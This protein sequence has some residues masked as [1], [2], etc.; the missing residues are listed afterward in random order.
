MHS[1]DIQIVICG[2]AGDGTIATGDIL[3]RAM[4]R[5][6]YKVISFDIYPA[7]IRGFGKCVA[8]V[9]I[10]TEQVYSLKPQCEILVSLDDSHAI[11]HVAEVRDFGAVVYEG[12]PISHVPEGGH[13]SAHVKPGQLPYALSQRQVSEQATGSGRSRNIVSLGF[14]AGLWN[15][16]AK[17]FREIITEKF[18]RKGTAVAESNM[19][20]F[21]AGFEVGAATFKL[22]DVALGPPTHAAE[23]ADVQMMTG[24]GAVVRACLEAGIDAFFGYPI[25]PATPIMERLFVEMPKAGAVALQ[26]ED[27]ISAI[28]ATL[29]ASYAGARAATATSGPGLALMTEMLGLGVMAEVPAVVFAC[30]RG[31]P[32][33]GLPTKTEQSDLNLAVHGGA[34]DAQRIVLAPTNVEGC[35]RCA[36]KAFDL[37]EQFQTPVI[38]LLDLYL[39]NRY[40]TV[41]PPKENPFEPK[42]AAGP[43]ALDEHEP[44]RRYATT[45]EF[46]SPRTLPGHE[47]GMHTITGLE[48]DEFGHPNDQSAVHMAM[49]AKRHR[50]LAGALARRDFNLCKRFG[51]EG[52]VD[53]GI[54]SWGS[55]F[56]ECLEAMLAAQAEGIRCAAM[57]VVML[58]PLPVDPIADFF[59]DCQEVLVP[60]L[61]YEGQ[62]ANLVTAAVGQPVS[63]LNRV[64][65]APMQFDEILDHVKSLA[66]GRTAA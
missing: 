58:S 16:P 64:T 1:T 56:G 65:G 24:N 40:E 26:T 63:R 66:R 52:P 49:S 39:C 8:R 22:D 44:Y 59:A 19:R 27:E 21:E 30:Q 53:V 45:R 60:E 32:A 36:G 20:A 54:L 7:E 4:A 3:K 55:T 25:T 5:A 12:N 34:G 13:I 14:V 47:G 28:G 48:H 31:G 11:G 9:R 61:N 10:T 57:K 37:A 23:G 42:A 18:A 15:L 35:Y 29:G 51:H 62:F 38:V 17:H 2:S 33:T 50:K 46:V 43:S 6:G 41:V